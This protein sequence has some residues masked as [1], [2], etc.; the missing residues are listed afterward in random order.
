MID[1]LRRAS[2]LGLRV[3]R[4]NVKKTGWPPFISGSENRFAP[5]VSKCHERCVA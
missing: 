2:A 4:S 3:D 5:F 1:F